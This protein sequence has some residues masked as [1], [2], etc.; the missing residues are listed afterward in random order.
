MKMTKGYSLTWLETVVFRLG[1]FRCVVDYF[2]V[3]ATSILF[4]I[5]PSLLYEHVTTK[6]FKTK[7]IQYS[8]DSSYHMLDIIKLKETHG[9]SDNKSTAPVLIFVHGGSWGSGRLCQYFLSTKRYGELIGASHAIILGYPVYPMGTMQMQTDAVLQGIDYI[10]NQSELSSLF[11]KKDPTKSS[12]L[13]LAGHSSGAH[14][15][16]L[17]IVQHML[18]HPNASPICD[19]YFGLSG[20]FDLVTHYQYKKSKRHLFGISPLIPAAEG[21]DN[22]KSVSPTL[23]LTENE[24]MLRGSAVMFPYVGLLHGLTDDV[25]PDSQSKKLLEAIQLYSK[26]C[27]CLILEVS[28]LVFRL[29][30][31]T[32]RCFFVIEIRSSRTRYSYVFH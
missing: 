30:L 18:N 16:M 15:A 27:K 14:I 28:G 22:L 20:P 32:L 24:K 26:K 13:L 8:Y 23:L 10:K 4:L 19:A 5:K 7:R 3:F 25:V 1:V 29:S 17:G 2:G 9:E 11:N 31:L 21:Y 6:L 12:P